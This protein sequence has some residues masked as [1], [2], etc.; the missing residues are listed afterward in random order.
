MMRKING[1]MTKEGFDKLQNNT[2]DLYLAKC[3]NDNDLIQILTSER[4]SICSDE[5][6]YVHEETM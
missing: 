6:N 2:A 4:K 1:L 3:R 5:N